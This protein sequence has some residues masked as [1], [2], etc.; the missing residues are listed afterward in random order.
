MQTCQE[1]KKMLVRKTWPRWYVK[2]TH[3]KYKVDCKRILA[4]QHKIK[5]KNKGQSMGVRL[6]DSI[7]QNQI[8]I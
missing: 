2:K 4:L 1:K 6:K 8:N 7:T 5:F 3:Q